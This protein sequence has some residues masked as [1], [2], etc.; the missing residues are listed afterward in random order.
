MFYPVSTGKN[1]KLLDSS[2]EPM[3][4]CM[5]VDSHKPPPIFDYD[6]F[7]FHGNY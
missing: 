7:K 5:M 4:V 2:D 1:K 3:I 6:S